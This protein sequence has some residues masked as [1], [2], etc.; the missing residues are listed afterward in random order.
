MWRHDY[1]ATS[2]ATLGL[3]NK[4]NRKPLV[5]FQEWKGN[6]RPTALVT[7]LIWALYSNMEHTL[8]YKFECNIPFWCTVSIYHSSTR[9]AMDVWHNIEA[10]SRNHCCREK[11]SKY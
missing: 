1:F 9:Q 7:G 8:P 3:Q 4:L 10:R 5:E 2:S 11:I 6:E